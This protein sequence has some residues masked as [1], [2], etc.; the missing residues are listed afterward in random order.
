MGFLTHESAHSAGGAQRSTTV[1]KRSLQHPVLFAHSEPHR[2]QDEMKIFISKIA[3]RG[4]FKK[5][6]IYHLTM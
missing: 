3:D 4:L 5:M 2:Y 1:C 6:S